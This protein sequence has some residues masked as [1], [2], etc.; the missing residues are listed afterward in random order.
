MW[1]VLRQG[2]LH[3]CYSNT[4]SAW[5]VHILHCSLIPKQFSNPNSD[6][7]LGDHGIGYTFADTNIHDERLKFTILI[8]SVF[9][10]GYDAAGIGRPD[11]G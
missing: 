8:R 1:M 10:Q 5:Q 4:F 7:S 3:Q 11:A 2:L 9:R 6:Q